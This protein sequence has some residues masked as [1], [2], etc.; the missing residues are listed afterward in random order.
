MLRKYWP[1][2][3]LGALVILFWFPVTQNN[4][5]FYDDF[6]F[7][8]TFQQ[9][10]A[11]VGYFFAPHN[12]HFMPMFK[13]TFLIMYKLFGQNVVPYMWLLILTHIINVCLFFYL[14]KLIFPYAKWLPFILAVLF[15][16]NSAYFEM[17]HWFTLLSYA[18]PLLF[19]QIS[20][21]FLHLYMN[22]NKKSYLFT[23]VACSFFIPMNNSIGFVG[24][25]FIFLYFYTII[26]KRV[27]ISELSKDFKLLWP[28]LAVWFFF[29][30]PY[31]FLIYPQTASGSAKM[32]ADYSKVLPNILSGVAGFLIKSWGISILMRPINI[33]VAGFLIFN[34]LVF[35]V[36]LPLYFLLNPKPERGRVLHDRGIALFSGLGALLSYGAIAVARTDLPSSAFMDWGRYQF[37]SVFF[38]IIF[39][40]NMLPSLITVFSSVFNKQRFKYY[41]LF[42]F[43]LYLVGQFVMI[44]VKSESPIRTE[45]LIINQDICVATSRSTST[46]I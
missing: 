39:I 46:D 13:F 25:L 3:L 12:E 22:E 42:L 21:I 18:L 37:F 7:I 36:F 43:I 31:F 4:E 6:D 40:G 32:L 9:N 5:F 28:Y 11:A 35:I 19:L 20:L 41:L 14:C 38:L 8:N 17:L 24:I 29:M 34:F 26:K 10:K 1:F 15:L 27:K 16:S 23:S 30:L 33:W 44:R 45:G 2:I